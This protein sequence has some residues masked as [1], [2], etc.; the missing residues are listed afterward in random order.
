MK[1]LDFTNKT[2]IIVEL[3]NTQKTRIMATIIETLHFLLIN[4]TSA[5]F[6]LNKSDQLLKKTV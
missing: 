2:T 4:D 3:L 1:L 6:V 5:P